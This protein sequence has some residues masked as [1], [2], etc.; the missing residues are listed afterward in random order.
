MCDLAWQVE[1]HFPFGVEVHFLFGVEDN[2][3]YGVEG[4]RPEPSAH[5]RGAGFTALEW[6]A[7]KGNLAI[8][9]WLLSDPRTEVASS[10]LRF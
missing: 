8:V 3:F 10:S 2:F 5:C 7:R 1:V 9:Q 6:A 4:V